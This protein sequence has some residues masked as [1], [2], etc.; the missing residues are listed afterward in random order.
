[1]KR[2]CKLCYS[3]FV[4]RTDKIFCCV[5]CKTIYHKKLNKVTLTAAEK[6]DKIL[7]RNRSIL[8]EILGKNTAYKKI[9]R[10]FLDTK[11]FNWHYITSYHINTQNKFVYYVYDFSW[12][13]F[14]DQEIVIKRIAKIS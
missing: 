5:R 2:K 10:V 9:P 14:S 13:I 12:M 7:H 4:G 1:M 8:L 3:S 11:K 6:I